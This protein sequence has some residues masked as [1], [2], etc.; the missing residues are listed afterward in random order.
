MKWDGKVRGTNPL[1]GTIAVTR[2][3]G[4]TI[5]WHVRRGRDFSRD[6]PSDTSA[7]I[8]NESAVQLTGFKD[9]ANQGKDHPKRQESDI[10]L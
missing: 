3:F 9:P 6:F 7:M 5:G 1:F 8:L 4:K 2:D 10:L